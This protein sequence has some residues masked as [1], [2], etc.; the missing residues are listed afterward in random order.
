MFKLSK[1]IAI[2]ASGLI[3]GGTALLL[4]AC[5]GTKTPEEPQ[6][7][8]FTVAFTQNGAVKTEV[9]V[10]GGEKVNPSSVPA[11]EKESE[12]LLTEWNF[13]FDAPV[14]QNLTVTAV[15]YTSGLVFKKSLSGGDYVVKGY[16][17]TAAEVIMPDNYKG[18][19]VT[20]V[21]ASA[22]ENNAA[23]TSVRFP[24]NLTSIGDKAFK[25]CRNLTDVDI[26]ETVTK[27]GANVFSECTSFTK[28]VFPSK[29][30]EIPSRAVQA[31]SF[32]GLITVPEG[33]KTI[34]A[35]AFACEATSILLPKSLRT[36]EELGLWYNLEEIY[37]AG[38]EAD[39]ETVAVS[40][41]EYTGTGGITFSAKSI[42][43]DKA[44]LYFYSE[45]GIKNPEYNYWHYVSGVPVP[46]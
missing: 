31:C 2:C 4:A 24:K 26:P 20:S 25:G 39:W 23:I 15:S 1:K 7:T 11:P 5:G 32:Y 27:L 30:T 3:L 9:T 13:D 21:Y 34:G 10:S 22:F 44:T 40:E 14:T 33:V 43:T 35:Y 12:S 28:I 8:A 6:K 36:I 42:T 18:G 45:T 29:L 16:S 37:Y 38:D 17:G 41:K 19:A 46:W